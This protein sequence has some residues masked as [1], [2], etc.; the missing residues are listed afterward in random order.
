MNATGIP[1]STSDE[2][3]LTE[4]QQQ[5]EAQLA[6]FAELGR[7][8]EEDD[9]PDETAE[10]LAQDIQDGT[11]SVEVKKT[12]QIV[13]CTGGPHCEIQWTEGRLP[14]IVCYGWFGAG[15]YERQLTENE[16]TALEYALG[17]WEILAEHTA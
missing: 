9:F 14:S 12:V 7:L 4:N 10:R 16:R 13:L 1:F 3:E 8:F 11:L 17:D 2:R 15:R 5:A 6:D